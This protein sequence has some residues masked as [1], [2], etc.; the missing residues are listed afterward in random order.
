[1]KF[2]AAL[3]IV[4]LLIGCSLPSQSSADSEVTDQVRSALHAEHLDSVEVR[5]SRGEVTLT[6]V[7]SNQLEREA[8]QREAERVTGV[9]G[10]A[11]RLQVRRQ[12]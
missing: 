11:N 3:A 5:V 10:V 4:S 2:V 12:R 1:V 9:R 8:A 6:G 7:V